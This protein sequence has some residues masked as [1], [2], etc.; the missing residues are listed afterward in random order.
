MSH[1]L[2]CFTKTD[3][4]I[5]H[6]C[7]IGHSM[8]CFWISKE[9]AFKCQLILISSRLKV[10]SSCINNPRIP[11]VTEIQLILIVCVEVLRPSQPYGV[12]LSV[13]HLPNHTFTGQGFFYTVKMCTIFA[14]NIRTP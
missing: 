5:S 11:M 6:S 8:N 9:N 1:I 10:N 3:S 4:L 13:V 14:L 7:S 2:L 12:M